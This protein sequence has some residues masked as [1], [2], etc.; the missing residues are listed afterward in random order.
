MVY[1]T[2]R[3]KAIGEFTAGELR[4]MISQAI[5]LPWLVPIALDLL[6]GDPLV[7]GDYYPGDLLKSVLTLSHQIWA[8]EPE[9]RN[10]LEGVLKDLVEVPVEL[11]DSIR[12]FSNWPA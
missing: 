12:E 9:W 5:G 2:L 10:R 1:T 7:E 8:Q 6:T 11:N 4:I 3:T